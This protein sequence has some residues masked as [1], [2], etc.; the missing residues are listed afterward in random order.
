M[1]RDVLPEQGAG[2]LVGSRQWPLLVAGMRKIGESDGVKA[3]DQHLNRLATD[4]SW[5][6]T[7]GSALVGRPVD[8]TLH[9]LT[10]P[11]SAPAPSR[12]RAPRAAA[13]STTT[14]AAATPGQ[15]AP[16]EAAVPAIRHRP[17]VERHGQPAAREPPVAPDAVRAV[18]GEDVA[19]ADQAEPDRAERD[20][21]ATAQRLEK[22]RCRVGQNAYQVGSPPGPARVSSSLRNPTHTIAGEPEMNVQC[23]QERRSGSVCQSPRKR[24][25]MVPLDLAY[26]DS[27]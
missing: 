15:Q 17:M 13:C 18:R 3:V 22:P 9:C 21:A 5:K 2:L 26:A 25:Q 7:S 12:V 6:E 8:A 11:P 20:A 24:W 19:A 4:T 14:P 27:R 10:V 1:V 23:S 16:A